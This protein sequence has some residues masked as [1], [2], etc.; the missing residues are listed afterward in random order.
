MLAKKI[1]G[2]RDVVL[3]NDKAIDSKASDFEKYRE[4]LFDIKQG[5]VVFNDGMVPTL[6]TIK[7]MTSKQKRFAYFLEH[8]Q[9]RVEYVVRFGL[10]GVRDYRVVDDLG[11]DIGMK[12][13]ETMVHAEYGTIVSD[14]WL[15]DC[16]LGPLELEVLS[17]MITYIS[18]ASPL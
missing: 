7:P 5:H 9:R 6:F 17:T 13:V 15:D 3:F 14:A 11:N 4:D 12:P 16:P 8:P 18:D 10:V 2:P 1:C